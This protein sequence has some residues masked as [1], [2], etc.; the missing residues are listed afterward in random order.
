MPYNLGIFA[1]THKGRTVEV[2]LEQMHVHNAT[3]GSGSK[4][5][6]NGIA[7]KVRDALGVRWVEYDNL[8]IQFLRDSETKSGCSCNCY[9][10]VEMTQ[11][12]RKRSKD[13][14]L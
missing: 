9:Y 7:A 11:H 6:Q 12:C 8:D 4:P 1:V 2:E 3:L 14:Y 13:C 5:L 10:C